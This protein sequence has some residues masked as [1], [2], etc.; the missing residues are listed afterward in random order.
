MIILQPLHPS[1]PLV[2]GV[3]GR[4]WVPYSS[5]LVHVALHA[6]TVVAAT[7]PSQSHACHESAN[8]CHWGRSQQQREHASW[9]LKARWSIQGQTAGVGNCKV[10]MSIFVRYARPCSAALTM[11][12]LWGFLW[13]PWNMEGHQVNE[14][15]RLWFCDTVS[16]KTITSNILLKL[17]D[18]RDRLLNKHVF[19]V[20]S[21][22]DRLWRRQIIWSDFRL[23]LH[24]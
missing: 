1:F 18:C 4:P 10:S 16:Y 15:L 22:Q 21:L 17:T 12:V 24:N 5:P 8:W 14:M 9:L 2:S 13:P 7:Y 19:N 20:F 11:R 23:V 6:G 3:Q